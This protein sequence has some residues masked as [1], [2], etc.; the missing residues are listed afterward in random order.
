MNVIE[1]AYRSFNFVTNETIEKLRLKHRLRV[2][3][4]LEDILMKNTLRTVG[5]DCTLNQEDL[6]ASFFL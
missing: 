1:A 2:V 6:Q 5:H 3:Q 4:S